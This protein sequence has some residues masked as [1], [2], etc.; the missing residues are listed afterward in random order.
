M[1]VDEFI[2]SSYIKQDLIS[3][4]TSIGDTSVRVWNRNEGWLLNNTNP[5]Q[6]DATL[7]EAKAFLQSVIDG[8]VDFM[9]T[10]FSDKLLSYEQYTELSDMFAQAADAYAD[11][12][13]KEAKAALANM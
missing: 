9:D 8:N 11:F 4:D 3:V 13:V 5:Q 6:E 1:S 10:E 12:T 7:T 2:K